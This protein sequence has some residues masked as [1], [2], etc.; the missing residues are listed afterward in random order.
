V[1]IIASSVDIKAPS[2]LVDMRGNM[3]VMQLQYNIISM[4]SRSLAIINNLFSLHALL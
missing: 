3:M 4:A 2:I 1:G